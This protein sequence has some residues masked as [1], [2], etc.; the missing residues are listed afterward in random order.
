MMQPIS[1]VSAPT[2]DH[3][4]CARSASASKIGVRAGDQVD[5]GGDHGRRVDQR[6]HRGRA[7]HRVGQPGLQRELAGLAARA[8][9]Q[10]QP[11]AR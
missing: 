11:D 8:E 5:A 3:D 7:L 10:Q 6:R 1:S 2:I 9:Q 4:G